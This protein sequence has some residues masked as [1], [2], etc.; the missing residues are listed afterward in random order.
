MN[1]TFWQ[2]NPAERAT[3]VLASQYN[4]EL[5]LDMISSM[6]GLHAQKR[7]HQTSRFPNGFWDHL[8]SMAD[9]QRPSQTKSQAAAGQSVQKLEPALAQQD[10]ALEDSNSCLPCTYVQRCK[11]WQDHQ[12][13][14]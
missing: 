9:R 6:R 13:G 1:A 11:V 12:N 8:D 3:A 10:S 4:P 7:S 14:Q 2:L 5:R